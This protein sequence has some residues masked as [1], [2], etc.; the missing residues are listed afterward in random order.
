[1]K[2]GGVSTKIFRMHESTI[3]KKNS[4]EEWKEKYNKMK[5]NICQWRRRV[6]T[7]Q[8]EMEQIQK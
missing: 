7:P 8:K 6:S 1:L 2:G 5:K 4:N 3:G